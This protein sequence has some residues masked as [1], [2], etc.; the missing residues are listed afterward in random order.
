MLGNN[1]AQFYRKNRRDNSRCELFPGS[2][3]G[4]LIIEAHKVRREGPFS[5]MNSS[6]RMKLGHQR[7]FRGSRFTS[8]RLKS[9]ASWTY[10]RLQ[11]RAKLPTGRGL[12]PAIWMVGLELCLC[13][14]DS[15]ETFLCISKL[16]E[17]QIYSD[18][19][20][21]DNGEIDLMEQVG[22]DPLRIH[23]TVHTKANNHMLGNHPSNSVIVPD[24][25]SNFKIYTMDWHADKIEMFVG[26]E[27]HPLQTRI[28]IWNKQGNW[29]TWYRH[30]RLLSS[31]YFSS[32]GH[33]INR[34]SSF[35][36]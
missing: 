23:S 12:W 30:C 10:G 35:S 28:F 6:N 22:F 34:S 11:V 18:A 8:A 36:M 27:S 24:A 14:E 19:Y 25:V 33:S 9:K 7:K 3:N 21:P 5:S 1:E 16:P 32:L 15:I 2:S 26:N 31:L 17:R 20:W 4:R 29:T 13:V